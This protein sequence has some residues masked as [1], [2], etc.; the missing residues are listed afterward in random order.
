MRR[1]DPVLPG[2]ARSCLQPEKTRKL[3]SCRLR[4]FCLLLAIPTFVA[5]TT[6][7]AHA[8]GPK[9]DA[10]F[11][12]S[13]VGNDTF[14]PNM[15]GLNGWEGTLNVKVKPLMGIEG[16]V[17]HYGLGAKSAVPRTTMVLLGPRVT[18]GA[19]GFHVFAHALAGGE[20]SNN[21]NGI[22]GG[23]LAVGFGGGVDVRLA[24]F[25]AWRVSADYLTT[26]TQSP[27]TSSHDRFSTG[28]VF[29]F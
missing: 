24:L 4:S 22:S 28:L 2:R 19:T 20:N 11:G 21:N 7:A 18:V 23:R 26:P 15:G 8:A 5:A 9:A 1:S 10:F 14:Y 29:R 13:R 3:N 6:P 27:E 25:F 12:Y 17:S 16:D